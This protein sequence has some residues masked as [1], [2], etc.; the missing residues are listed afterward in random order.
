MLLIFAVLI[1]LAAIERTRQN[2]R[3]NEKHITE[4][5][6]KH[7]NHLYGRDGPVGIKKLEIER[8]LKERG[9]GKE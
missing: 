6:R 9:E 5:K 1:A 2:N 8:E 3:D 4:E 7:K